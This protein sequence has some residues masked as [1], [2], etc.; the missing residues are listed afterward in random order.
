MTFQRRRLSVN[1][2]TPLVKDP[3]PPR[4]FAEISEIE[5]FNFFSFFVC[6]LKHAGEGRAISRLPFSGALVLAA[7]KANLILFLKKSN[8]FYVLK[9]AGEGRAISRLQ[10]FSALVWAA[11]KANLILFLKKG[12]C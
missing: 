8:C 11:F 9:H 6:F 4:E 5:I 3:P 10:F 2:L 12:N 7:F 1:F